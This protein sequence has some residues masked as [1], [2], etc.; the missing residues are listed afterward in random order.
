[1]TTSGLVITLDPDPDRASG[2]AHAIGSAGPFT[3]GDQLGRCLTAAL[4][5]DTPADARF[6]HEWLATLPGV[7]R[8]DLAFVHADT[9]AEETVHDC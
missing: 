2:A 4:E 9:V 6:W 3:L 1:M 8:V 5:A 7:V